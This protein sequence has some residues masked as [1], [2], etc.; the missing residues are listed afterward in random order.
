MR[1]TFASAVIGLAL[2]AVSA[3]SALDMSVGVGGFFGNDFGG[4]ADANLSASV[5]SFIEFDIGNGLL[6]TPYYGGGGYLFFDLTFAEVSVGYFKCGGTWSLEADVRTNTLLNLTGLDAGNYS[7][8]I[9]SSFAFANLGLLGKYPVGVS[10]AV[11]LF[12]ALGVDYR[13]C[14]TGRGKYDLAGFGEAVNSGDFGDLVGNGDWEDGGA[15]SALFFKFGAG[16]DFNLSGR[17]FLRSE[18]LYGIRLAS[19]AED[20]LIKTLKYEVGILNA[21]VPI[22]LETQTKTRLG[23]GLTVRAGAGFKL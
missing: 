10:E 15:F 7:T 13:L 4:G 9:S 14:F 8:E 21:S 16:L 6:K 1:K 18:F 2:G 11:T 12:P 17:F 3:V 22:R 20:E 5:I 19:K 23:H